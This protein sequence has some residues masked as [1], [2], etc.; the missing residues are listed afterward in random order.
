[1]FNSASSVVIFQ[2]HPK[3]NIHLT[4]T[5][6]PKL[7]KYLLFPFFFF[8]LT[9]SLL[10]SQPVYEPVHKSIYPFLQK[11]S[12][13]GIIELEDLILPL[14]RDYIAKNLIL[15]KE[16][17]DSYSNLLSQID[18][19]EL[20]FYL[21]DYGLEIQMFQDKYGPDL[22][23]LIEYR[24]HP[25]FQHSLFFSGFFFPLPSLQLRWQSIQNK[26][27]SNFRY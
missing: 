16:H 8:I 17:C 22:S 15:I 7:S 5:N 25:S 24:E 19:E 23:S 21:L 27:R 13:K 4:S 3:I 2:P 9:F 6:M 10:H 14:T 20:N 26:S 12:Q 1:M 18:S 11:M